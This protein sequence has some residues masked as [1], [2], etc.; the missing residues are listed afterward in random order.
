MGD[1]TSDLDII[2]PGQ[3]LLRGS[4]ED[5]G[6][7]GGGDLQEGQLALHRRGQVR[8]PQEEHLHQLLLGGGHTL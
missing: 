4:A 2:L 1:N 7:A 5:V 3:A 8:L 6:G